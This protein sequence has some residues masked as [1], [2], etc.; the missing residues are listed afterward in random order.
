M[1]FVHVLPLSFWKF[2]Y[3]RYIVK[4]GGKDEGVFWGGMKVSFL[5]AGGYGDMIEGIWDEFWGCVVIFVDLG[6]VR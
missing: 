6:T 2:G 1:G 4:K 5:R 3:L